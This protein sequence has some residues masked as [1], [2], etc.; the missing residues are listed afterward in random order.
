MTK[1]STN[2]KQSSVV[3]ELYLNALAPISH[4]SEEERESAIKKML[5]KEQ[6]NKSLPALNQHILKVGVIDA[7]KGYTTEDLKRFHDAQTL[8]T[9]ELLSPNDFVSEGSNSVIQKKR[10]QT[11]RI[12]KNEDYKEIWDFVK[13]RIRRGEPMKSILID[14]VEC[15]SDKGFNERKVQRAIKW[16]KEQ[17]H[18]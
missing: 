18:S 16:G 1:K 11:P 5:R 6:I 8:A 3:T 17:T 13:G 14:T 15:F 4:L 9:R 2:R 12:R 10:A 7:A